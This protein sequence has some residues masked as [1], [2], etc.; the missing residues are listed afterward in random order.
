MSLCFYTTSA[1][2]TVRIA[3][4]HLIL[5]MTFFPFASQG[6]TMKRVCAVASQNRTDAAQPASTVAKLPTSRQRR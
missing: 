3:P 4:T 5:L 6:A 1:D 2:I